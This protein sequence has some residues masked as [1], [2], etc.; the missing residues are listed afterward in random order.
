[1]HSKKLNRL[2]LILNLKLIL[3]KVMPEQKIYLFHLLEL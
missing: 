3:L 2:K 1:M